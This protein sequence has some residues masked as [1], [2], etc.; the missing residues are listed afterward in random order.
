[1]C[2]NFDNPHC[3]LILHNGNAEA[4]DLNNPLISTEQQVARL[5][6]LE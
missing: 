2:I 5:L 1:M 3:S 6:A 4:W